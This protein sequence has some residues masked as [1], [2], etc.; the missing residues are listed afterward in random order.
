MKFGFL[1]MDFS[2]ILIADKS[3]WFLSRGKIETSSCVHSIPNGFQFV[4]IIIT[5]FGK[6]FALQYSIVDS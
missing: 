5:D 6:G 2:F 1:Q 3:N 4:S